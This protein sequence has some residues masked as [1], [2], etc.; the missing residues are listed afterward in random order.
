MDILYGLYFL[1]DGTEKLV[2]NIY[3]F[4]II[5]IEWFVLEYT[6]QEDKPPYMKLFLLFYTSQ[7]GEQGFL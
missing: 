7:G 2:K 4:Y 3:F 6:L 5:R 1:L